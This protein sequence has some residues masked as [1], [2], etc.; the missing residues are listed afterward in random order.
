MQMKEE[1]KKQ[2]CN[3]KQKMK[4]TKTKINKSA[5]K[6]YF[7]NEEKWGANEIG[8]NETKKKKIGT[9]KVRG[10]KVY[11]KDRCLEHICKVVMFCCTI[12]LLDSAYICYLVWRAS[13]Q[14]REQRVGWKLSCQFPLTNWR[15]GMNHYGRL[16]L[17]WNGL[18]IPRL[19]VKYLPTER[20]T[21]NYDQPLN[22]P[23]PHLLLPTA[24]HLHTPN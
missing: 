10:G 5:V 16:P 24:H 3:N 21:L 19:N 12:P 22:P 20:C 15:R 4:Q 18:I 14:W 13:V 17:V 23:L 2:I 9:R 8:R 7:Q 6:K 1:Q 11:C